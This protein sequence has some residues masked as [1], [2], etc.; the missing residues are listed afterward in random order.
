MGIR[1]FVGE[2]GFELSRPLTDVELKHIESIKDGW[3]ENAFSVEDSDYVVFRFTE[4]EGADPGTDGIDKPL[5][6]LLKYLKEEG[7]TASGEIL[8]SSDY[9]DY[10][11]DNMAIIVKEDY[12]IKHEDM[13]LRNMDDRALIE[14]LKR[15]GYTEPEKIEGLSEEEDEERDI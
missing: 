9:R 15:R 1:I 10:Y 11:Y 8:L 13:T 14:E 7:I 3:G 12:T 5:N 4:M 6:E 2:D